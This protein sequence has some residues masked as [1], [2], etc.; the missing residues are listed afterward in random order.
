MEQR[1]LI[2]YSPRKIEIVD[3]REMLSLLERQ[4]ETQED[5]PG[6]LKVENE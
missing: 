2:R 1:N 6:Q 5:V 3:R 4:S